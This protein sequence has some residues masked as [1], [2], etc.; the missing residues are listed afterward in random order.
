MMRQHADSHTAEISA[1]S[2]GTDSTMELLTDELRKRLP[3]LYAQEADP[4]PVVHAKFFTP[5][6]N[7][8][9]YVTEGSP[10][11][12]DYRFF[13]Y[14]QGLAEEWGYFLLSELTAARGPLGLPVDRDLNFEPGRFTEVVP[15]GE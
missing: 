7:W 8:T 6:S 14:V 2:K 15:A 9:W 10:A 13:G 5:D 11:G 4:D 12:D 3:P 1:A